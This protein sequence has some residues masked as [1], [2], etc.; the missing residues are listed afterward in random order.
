MKKFAKV[1]AVAL[2]C[3]LAVA[4]FVACAPNSDPEKAKA[5]LEKN[6][7]K[8]LHDDKVIPAALTLLGVK[9]VD[10]AVTG[11]KTVDDGD[12]K[13]TESVTIVYFS[14]ADAANDAWDEMQ[15]YADDQN[16]DK[17]SDWTVKKS[18]KMV[19]FGT[20]AAIKAAR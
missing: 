9:G 7:Y 12:S 11:T 8:A 6:D 13:K 18:G 1:F 16:K 2:V 10:S 4:M 3:V 19:Y 17:D 20:S 15:K 14:S 5:A